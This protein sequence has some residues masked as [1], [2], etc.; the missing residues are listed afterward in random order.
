MQQILE[1][2]TLLDEA[3]KTELDAGADALAAGKI[4]AARETADS[5][6][7]KA[8]NT[9]E[10]LQFAGVVALSENRANIAADYFKR[11]LSVCRVP[12]K[13]ARTWHGLGIALNQMGDQNQACDAFARAVQAHPGNLVSILEWANTLGAMN[14]LVEAEA[15][16]RKAM[17]RFPDDTRIPIMLGN[18]LTAQNRQADALQIYDNVLEKHSDSA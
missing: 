1:S 8:G 9:Y 18:I 7:T 2:N 4:E 3:L 15:I 16:L 17:S 12:L 10:V 14:R 11:A 6:L 5:L 13:M